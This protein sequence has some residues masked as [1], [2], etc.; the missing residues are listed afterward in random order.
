METAAHWHVPKDCYDPMANYLV[1]GWEPGSCFSAVLANDFFVAIQYSHP[2]NTIEG[3]KAVTAWISNYFP[4]RAW[5]SYRA[6]DDW[7]NLKEGQRRRYLEEAN[8]IY[9]EQQEI[10][11]GLQGATSQ[12]P[13]LW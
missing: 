9:T 13:I 10:I 11:M 1:H 3:F 2:A 6:L 8:L 7:L 4:R 5:G 12:E